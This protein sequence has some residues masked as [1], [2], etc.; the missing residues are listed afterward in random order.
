MQILAGRFPNAEHE[1]DHP[2][3]GN[4]NEP[5]SSG[6]TVVIKLVLVI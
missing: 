1:P 2:L 6:V 3:G 5:Y 4:Q